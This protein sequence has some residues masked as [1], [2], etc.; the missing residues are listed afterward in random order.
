M[1]HCNCTAKQ[2]RTCCPG[3]QKLIYARSRFTAPAESCY[4]PTEGEALA[5][6]WS[7]KHSS[8]F[9]QRCTNLIISVDHKSLLAIFN[10]RDL[11]S[12]QN[13][14]LQSLNKNTLGWSFQIVHAQENG[15]GTLM[16][17]LN[18]QVV[19]LWVLTTLTQNTYLALS[20][21]TSLDMMSKK[22]SI[23]K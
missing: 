17:C 12:I 16:P 22:R 6:M 21:N 2:I 1:K 3:D 9:I 4:S 11:H 23:L 20:K 10:N 8:M 5:L 15:I 14:C 19:I 7:L 13:P 18:I